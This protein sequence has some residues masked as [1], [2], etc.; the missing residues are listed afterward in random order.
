MAA[1][2]RSQCQRRAHV[3]GRAGLGK[4]GASEGLPWWIVPGCS[5]QKIPF[6]PQPLQSQGASQLPAAGGRWEAAGRGG[7]ALEDGNAEGTLGRSGPGP[8]LGGCSWKGPAPVGM[9]SASF[10][11]SQRRFP[12]INLGLFGM[13]VWDGSG[14]RNADKG[15][16]VCVRLAE[17]RTFVITQIPG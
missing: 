17:L 8:A 10:A 3:L 9:E 7:A 15:V 4:A 14:V 12:E 2:P 11:P 1:L 6:S 5:C 13:R 16:C